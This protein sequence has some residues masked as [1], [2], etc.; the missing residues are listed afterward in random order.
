VE[1]DLTSQGV[2]LNTGVDV[3]HS[4]SDRSAVVDVPTE[5]FI[6][7]YQIVRLRKRGGGVTDEDHN[8]WGLFS[9]DHD[10]DDESD[11]LLGWEIDWFPGC[12]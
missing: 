3:E 2:P 9:D 8:K 11:E 12:L 7:A 10:G 1:A 5:P 6:L 4:R